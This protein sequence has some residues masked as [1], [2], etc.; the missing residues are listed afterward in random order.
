VNGK[1]VPLVSE[2]SPPG[3]LDE[4]PPILGPDSYA[5]G[6]DGQRYDLKPPAA[7]RRASKLDKASAHAKP[8]S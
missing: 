7:S 6:R 5:I 1:S 8:S 2:D 3:D 4:I